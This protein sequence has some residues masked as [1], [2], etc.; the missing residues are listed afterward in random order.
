[1]WSTVAS[2]A[3]VVV[4]PSWGNSAAAFA[5]GAVAAVGAHRVHRPGPAFLVA[6]TAVCVVA[7]VGI[8]LYYLV[9]QGREGRWSVVGRVTSVVAVLAAVL[10][11]SAGALI[12]PWAVTAVS[13]S[14]VLSASVAASVWLQSSK[15]ARAGVLVIVVAASAAAFGLAVHTCP[16]LASGAGRPSGV[17]CAVAGAVAAVGVVALQGAAAVSP[18][19]RYSSNVIMSPLE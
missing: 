6:G 7:M 14:L 3:S 1:M 9:L 5:A 15:A 11:S 18:R 4:R 17:M 10:G 13:G 16:L 19:S 12:N 2:L 8:L